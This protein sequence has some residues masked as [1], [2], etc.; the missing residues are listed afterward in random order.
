[1][2]KNI[3]QLVHK[4]GSRSYQLLCD[5]D[6]P[7]VE[8]KDALVQFMGY[9]ANVENAA[10]ASS[11]PVPASALEPVVE[12]VAPV[13]VLPPAETVEPAVPV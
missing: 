8:V 3:T 12:P 2:L 13:E 7:L 6:S 4:V 1:M 9:A 5:S 10:K 11:E